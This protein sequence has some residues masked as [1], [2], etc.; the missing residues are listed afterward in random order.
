[1]SDEPMQFDELITSQLHE[2]TCGALSVVV[3]FMEL[4]DRYD[5]EGAFE[6]ITKLKDL[7]S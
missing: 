2:V 7:L 6:M 4:L 3:D 1:M 5:E